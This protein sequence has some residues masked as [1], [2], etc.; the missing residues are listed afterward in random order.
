MGDEMSLLDRLRPDPTTT[1]TKGHPT[2]TSRTT[3][4]PT[5]TPV[6][7]RAAARAAEATGVVMGGLTG[8]WTAALSWLC[9]T[10][11]VLLVWAA[12]A[13]TTAPWSQAV[14]VATDGW[15]LLHRIGI[16]VPGGRVGLLPLAL[17]MIPLALCWRAGRRIGAGL[18]AAAGGALRAGSPGGSPRDRARRMVRA[19]APSLGGFALG[20]AVVSWAAAVLARGDGVA[21]VLWQALLLGPLVPLLGAA[22]AA[23]RAI[24]APVLRTLADL[25][26]MPARVR[27]TAR[28]AGAAVAALTGAGGLVVVAALVAQHDRVAALHTALAPGVIG[29]TVLT[30][31]QAALLPNVAVWCVSF[32]AGPGFV[33][34][35]DSLVT[36]AASQLT[37]LPLVPV[38]GAVPPPGPMPAALGAVLL[39]PLL[40]GAVLGRAVARRRARD[41]A[42][43]VDAVCE[44]LTAAGLCAG[45]LTVLVALSGGPAGP[46][47]L[48]S[49]GASPWRAGLALA[50][51]LGAGAAA[52]AWITHRRSRA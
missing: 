3:T 8:V 49:V 13:Q 44:A 21:P 24:G 19:L 42:G 2:S 31:A 5:A 48:A 9:L 7:T 25:V 50:G 11:P 32:L 52:A 16:D 26:R 23:L 33:V 43:L 46:G 1:T 15:L 10:L 41:G 37:L 4:D 51:E 47:A 45:T 39:L 40:V 12:S 17:A 27:R 38:L 20:Y 29:G 28:A 30:L 36:P 6:A 22:P 14:R 18:A 34:G 35:A